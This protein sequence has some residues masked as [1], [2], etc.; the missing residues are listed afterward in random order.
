[1]SEQQLKHFQNKQEDFPSS[2]KQASGEF[3]AF[4]IPRCGGKQ[5]AREAGG[6][7]GTDIYTSPETMSQKTVRKGIVFFHLVWEGF[8]AQG[9]WREGPVSYKAVELLTLLRTIYVVVPDTFYGF[10]PHTPPLSPPSGIHQGDLGRRR[11]KYLTTGNLFTMPGKLRGLSSL[12]QLK[13]SCSVI[14]G[15]VL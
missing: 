8:E 10:T 2:P 3:Y 7:E 4:S 6:Q 12:I 9:A 11:G 14:W 13:H 15:L 1:M 5:R